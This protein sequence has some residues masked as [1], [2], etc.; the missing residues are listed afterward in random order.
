ML[1]DLARTSGC[2]RQSPSRMHLLRV[3]LMGCGRIFELFESAGLVY[4]LSDVVL[5]RRRMESC[6]LALPRL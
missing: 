6:A 2:R 4:S 1:L 3:D 5:L